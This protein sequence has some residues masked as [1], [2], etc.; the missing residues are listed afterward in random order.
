MR[1]VLVIVL[2]ITLLSGLAFS[3]DRP[4]TQSDNLLQLS[5]LYKSRWNN[6]RTTQYYNLISNPSPAQKLLNDDPNLEVI[7]ININCTD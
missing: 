4:V 6:L 2:F 3:Q 5:E 7:Y 1:K